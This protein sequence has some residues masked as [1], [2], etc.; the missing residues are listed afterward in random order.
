MTVEIEIS[1]A[2]SRLRSRGDRG[3]IVGCGFPADISTDRECFVNL[4]NLGERTCNYT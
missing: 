1:A 3:D 2:D 4:R